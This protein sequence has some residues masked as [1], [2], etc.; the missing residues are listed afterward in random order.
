MEENIFVINLARRPERWEKWIQQAQKW[1][2]PK[3]QRFNAI[4]GLTLEMTP[5]IE[6]LFRNRKELISPGAI[7]CAL[8]HMFL[9]LKLIESQLPYI[10]IF[11][12]DAQFS[13]HFKIP[14]LPIGWDMF[15]LGGVDLPNFKPPGKLYKDNIIIPVLEGPQNYYTCAY[16]LSLNGA[17]KLLK[18][19]QEK[20]FTRPL[21]WFLTDLFPAM[22]VYC[23]SPLS[24][25]ANK[26]YGSDIQH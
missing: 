24:V 3:Y 15:Y 10:V 9:W 12:D 22:N 1:G 21:D 13:S 17:L 16:L 8:S 18:E 20:G 7:G 14:D 11:E 5:E 6:S 25:Y 4:D 19:V 26:D 2:V 23:Y